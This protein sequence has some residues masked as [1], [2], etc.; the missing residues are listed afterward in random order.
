MRP[1]HRVGD[2]VSGFE[3]LVYDPD[4]FTELEKAVAV[5]REIQLSHYHSKMQ[6]MGGRRHGG[7]FSGG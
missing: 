3:H 6:P 5:S 4:T 2:E 1:T 7:S